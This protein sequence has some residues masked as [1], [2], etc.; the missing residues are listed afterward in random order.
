MIFAK[1]NPE[2]FLELLSDPELDLYNT[3]QKAIDEGLL[4][5]R[6]GGRDVFYNIGKNK[7]KMLTVPFDQQPVDAVSAYLKTNDGIEF[8]KVLEKKLVTE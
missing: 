6:N 3:A 1:Q 8:L 7:K 5:V 4:S 2:E